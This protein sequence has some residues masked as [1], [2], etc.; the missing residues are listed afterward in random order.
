LPSR[1]TWW[2]AL[3][4]LLPHKGDLKDLLLLRGLL[5]C[6][7]LSENDVLVGDAMRVLLGQN[8]SGVWG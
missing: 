4:V 5:L 1:R 2:K 8:V 6:R 3:Q 7:S